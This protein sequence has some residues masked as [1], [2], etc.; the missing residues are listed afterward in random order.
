[1]EADLAVGRGIG[2]TGGDDPQHTRRG[3]APGVRGIGHSIPHVTSSSAHAEALLGIPLPSPRGIVSREPWWTPLGGGERPEGSNLGHLAPIGPEMGRARQ[4]IVDHGGWTNRSLGVTLHYSDESDGSGEWDGSRWGRGGVRAWARTRADEHPGRAPDE[5]TRLR[6]VMLR[7]GRGEAEFGEGLVCVPVPPDTCTEVAHTIAN[8]V[9]GPR[10]DD[11]DG[12]IEIAGRLVSLRTLPAPLLRPSAAPTVDR[13][14]LDD[15][16]REICAQRRG[17]VESAHADRRLLN[18][19]SAAALDAARRRAAA[20]VAELEAPRAA[21]APVSVVAAELPPDDV[22]PRLV[23]LCDWI[24]ALEP[25]ESPEAL[26]L[27]EAFDELQAAAEATDDDLDVGD[28]EE[29]ESRVATR[30]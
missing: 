3:G 18:Y 8:S 22:T 29:L 30:G 24:D 9:I 17:R 19:R 21:G 4:E 26:A 5:S 11:V 10:A 27:A 23:S 28:L 15:L 12:T 1:M 16:W 6:L 14:M 25:V 20:V 7:T 13:L 2:A